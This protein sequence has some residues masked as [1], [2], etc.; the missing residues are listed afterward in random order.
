MTGNEV[1]AV[2]IS[3]SA[4]L[5]ELMFLSFKYNNEPADLYKQ[6]WTNLLQVVLSKSLNIIVLT[7]SLVHLILVLS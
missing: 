7:V 4:A 2:H 3:S 6:N 5:L 1:V